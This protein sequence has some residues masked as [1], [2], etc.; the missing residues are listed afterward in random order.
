MIHNESEEKRV[1]KKE[2]SGLLTN[3]LQDAIVK[4]TGTEAVFDDL[5]MP[6]AGKTGL[7][8]SESDNWF[9][10]YTPYYTTGIWTGYDN[11]SQYAGTTSCQR[12]WKSI[13]EQLHK[14]KEL[15]RAEFI[16]PDNL[17]TCEV[18]TKSGK[19]AVNGVCDEAQS[20][21]CTRL[22]YYVK[23]TEPTDYCDRHVKYKICKKSGR[24]A[25]DSCPSYD[26]KSIVYL[27]KEETGKTNDTPFILPDNLVKQLYCNKH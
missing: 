10:G 1:M 24:L 8:L 16:L 6:E 9:E 14:Q 7:S 26:V 22:E 2:T 11:G 19:L 12:M 13:M 27:I 4:G 23:G 21:D 25:G 17:V 20:G 18:C 15:S 3:A 5:D